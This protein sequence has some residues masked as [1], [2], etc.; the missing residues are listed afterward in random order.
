[1]LQLYD[2]ATDSSLTGTQATINE[3]REYRIEQQSSRLFEQVCHKCFLRSTVD[4]ARETWGGGVMLIGNETKIEQMCDIS[5]HR[6]KRGRT[7]IN[8][9][10]K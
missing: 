6:H 2:C 8:F 5:F 10:R 7:P 9:I 3:R 1:M 4:G